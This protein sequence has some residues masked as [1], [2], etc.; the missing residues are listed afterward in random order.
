M[1]YEYVSIGYSAS[2]MLL[3]LIIFLKAT[4]SLIVKFYLFLVASLVTFGLCGFLSP[5][6]LT[7]LQSGI[8]GSVGAFLFALF[9][10]FFLH[11]MIIMVRREELLKSPITIGAVYFAG[12]FSYTFELLGLI[13]NP[14]SPHVGISSMG[15]VF[16]VTWMSVI[17]SIGIALLFT[18]LKGFSDRGMK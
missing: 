4:R 8:I 15:Y 2:N 16:L 7:P 6:P 12:L 1:L 9:P 3:A 17:F 13:P 18:F 11:F 14:I 5:L 10:F